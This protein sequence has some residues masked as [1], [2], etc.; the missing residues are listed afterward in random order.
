MIQIWG[1]VRPG[2]WNTEYGGDGDGSE[3]RRLQDPMEPA[4]AFVVYN[5]FIVGYEHW[6]FEMRPAT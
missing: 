6:E 2:R 4:Q 3:W 1:R 5:R